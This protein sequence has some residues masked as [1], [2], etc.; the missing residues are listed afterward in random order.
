MTRALALLRPFDSLRIQ[1]LRLLSPWVAP[2]FTNRERRVLWLGLISVL[3]SLVFTLF[4]PLLSIAVSP[5]VL[6]VPHL[7]S[8]VRYLVIRQQL[9]RNALW[10][11]LAGAPLLIASVIGAREVSLLAIPATLAVTE[12]PWERRA[13]L[14]MVW[15]ALTWLA[16]RFGYQFQFA[17]LHL[18]NVVGLVLWWFW[19]PR[20]RAHWA[21]PALVFTA[22][23]A[24]LLGAADPLMSLLGPWLSVGGRFS[25]GELVEQTAPVA[26]GVMG[27]R[28]LLSFA[29]LQ[30]VHY[31]VWLRLMPEDDRPRVAP[32]SFRETFRQLMKEFSLPVLAL[33]ALLCVSLAVWALVDVG[34]ARLGYLHV[35]GFH[36]YL[37]LAIAA[38]LLL[39]RRSA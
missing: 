27:A 5:I 39:Q 15:L 20:P 4:F 19:R 2:L 16:L 25:F 21:I 26:D 36:G 33:V 18:H 31:V 38:R 37:E 22:S 14:L 32:R 7:L 23:A 29:F 11:V 3:A 10:L 34:A 13:P 17:F 9:H 35:A 1:W 24:I 28:L 8:D 12:G 30:S 6:G